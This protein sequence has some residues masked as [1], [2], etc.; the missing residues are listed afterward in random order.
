VER[1]LA[2]L[3]SESKPGTTHKRGGAF[4]FEFDTDKLGSGQ[5]FYR[6]TLSGGGKSV[7]VSVTLNLENDMVAGCI[8]EARNL[9]H[10]LKT[11]A[12][13]SLAMSALADIMMQNEM[14]NVAL[15]RELGSTKTRRTYGEVFTFLTSKMVDKVNVEGEAV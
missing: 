13:M 2:G 9:E 14:F 11:S 15:D 3:Q 10:A 8:R 4:R 7:S 5:S 12:L 1:P 6:G